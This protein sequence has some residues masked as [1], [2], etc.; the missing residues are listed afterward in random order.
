VADAGTAAVTDRDDK[1]RRAEPVAA[2]TPGRTPTV[3]V[4]LA[5]QDFAGVARVRDE[6]REPTSP[7]V[8]VNAPSPVIDPDNT[9]VA[10]LFA[11]VVGLMEDRIVLTRREREVQTAY[12][13]SMMNVI[14]QHDA[15]AKQRDPGYA[16]K[17]AQL[18]TWRKTEVDP[19]RLRVAGMDGT[20]GLIGKLSERV[21]E[22]RE[23]VGDG[24][25]CQET[26]AIAGNVRAIRRRLVAALVAGG[27]AIGGLATQWL[28]ARD[29]GIRESA[30]LMFRIEAVERGPARHLDNLDNSDDAQGNHDRSNQ[31]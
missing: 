6:E 8:H 26:R 15:H 19:F 1:D 23:D 21:D 16:L 24:Q 14:L 13:S 10:E 3:R 7:G 22:I 29:A 28:R 27:L 31:D 4:P 9:P 2:R 17:L 11:Q 5:H 18:E 30:H 25:C 12:L 20:N